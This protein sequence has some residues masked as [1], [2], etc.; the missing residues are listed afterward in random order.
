MET[1]VTANRS[2]CEEQM[3]IISRLVEAEELDLHNI[4]YHVQGGSDELIIP[5]FTLDTTNV[6]KCGMPG[7]VSKYKI[8]THMS[9]HATRHYQTK[10]SELVI[11]PSGLIFRCHCET[12][13]SIAQV[14]AHYVL[15]DK[16]KREEQNKR[17]NLTNIPV[18][19]GDVD[20]THP[21]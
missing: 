7:C 8:S 15:H 3:P 20:L 9:K 10:H 6:A 2:F 18:T 4:L 12:I 13:L 5:H 17:N 11:P 16:E 14:S 1:I 19:R 21:R